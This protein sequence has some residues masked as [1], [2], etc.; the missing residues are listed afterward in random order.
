LKKS[1]HRLCGVGRA[2]VFAPKTLLPYAHNKPLALVRVTGL[3]CLDVSAQK[4]RAAM[5]KLLAK[6]GARFHWADKISSPTMTIVVLEFGTKSYVSAE[7]L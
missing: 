2:L 4:L 1:E 3:L 6:I 7:K 5:T